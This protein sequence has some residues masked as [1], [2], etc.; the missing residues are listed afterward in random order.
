[1]K[2][3]AKVRLLKKFGIFNHARHFVYKLKSTSLA[4]KEFYSSFVKKGSL[5]F[6]IGANI[7]QKTEIFLKL[8]AKVI[9]VE[10][11]EDCVRFLKKKFQKNPNVTIVNKA[12]DHVE[13]DKEL[14]VC[15]AN[16][17]STMSQKWLA[18]VKKR[19]WLA[20]MEWGDKTI[21]RATTQIG[22]AS[23]RERV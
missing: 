15:E 2:L 3:S 13:G 16:T 4:S 22:R 19:D 11:Q 21:V 8:G 5:C 14:Y 1:M 10:P 20:G 23:C 18:D 7:G 12:V 17:L 6:D 9:A